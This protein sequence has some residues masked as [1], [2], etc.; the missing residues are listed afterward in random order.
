MTRLVDDEQPGAVGGPR[1]VRLLAVAHLVAHPRLEDDDAAVLQLGVDL[2]L[3]AEHDVSLLAPMIGDVAG[4]VLDH[5]DADFAE[6]L[7]P[8]E[9]DPGDAGVLAR[10]D[11]R[12][13]DG[14]EGDSVQS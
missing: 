7:R 8:P 5:P 13:V 14:F 11:G 4:R 1:S 3:E 6:L 2:A 9:G 12:P 10:G